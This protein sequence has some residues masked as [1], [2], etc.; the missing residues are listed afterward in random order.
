MRPIARLD[1]IALRHEACLMALTSAGE[2]ATKEDVRGWAEFYER[3]Q[4]DGAASLEGVYAA[5]SVRKLSVVV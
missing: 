5:P 2:G 4:L 3:I 1:M